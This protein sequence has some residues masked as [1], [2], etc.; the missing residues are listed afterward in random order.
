MAH[1]PTYTAWP[2]PLHKG[3]VMARRASHQWR[4]GAM[5]HEGSDLAGWSLHLK[6]GTRPQ[7]FGEIRTHIGWWK[8]DL[9]GEAKTAPRQ[10]GRRSP[11]RRSTGEV[12]GSASGSWGWLTGRTG[13]RVVR[14]C[15]ALCN[16]LDPN[17]F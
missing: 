8:G 16:W 4:S 14:V 15:G 6:E 17:P 5:A 10:G 9:T 13:R 11:L 12:I 7:L 3:A 2:E 1:L